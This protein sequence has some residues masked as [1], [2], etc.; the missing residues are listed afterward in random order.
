MK[1]IRYLILTAIILPVG[2]VLFHGCSGMQRDEGRGWQ[3][4]VKRYYD[5]NRDQKAGLVRESL[6][7]V[8]GINAQ[9]V[10]INNFSDYTEIVYGQYSTLDDLNAKKDLQFIKSLVV[11]DQGVPPFYDAHLEQISEPDPPIQPEWVIT[12]TKGYWTLQIA[13][14]YGEKRKQAAVEL[15]SELRKEGIPGY[16]HHGPVKSLVM[17]GSYPYNAVK[18]PGNQS[19]S[20][21]IKPA[22]PDL[23]KWKADYP[24]MIINAGYAHVRDTQSKKQMGMIPSQIIKIPRP[25]ASLW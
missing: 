25:G 4:L 5:E 14:F 12:R 19:I 18:M 13:Q 21:D 9:N 16:V 15:V 23:Q 3:I 1:K 10:R 8:Q 11:Q 2:V 22:D 7:R 6:R 17:I 24:Y 20:Q